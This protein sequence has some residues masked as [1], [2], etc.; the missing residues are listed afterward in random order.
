MAADTTLNVPAE[1]GLLVGAYDLLGLPVFADVTTWPSH[2]ASPSQFFV[3]DDGSFTYTP[4]PGF[5]AQAIGNLLPL[6]HFLRGLRAA[7][8][9][10]ADSATVLGLAWPIALFAALA[11]LVAVWAARR[12]I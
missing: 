8:I 12:R 4:A 10:G 9:R 5:N 7:L 6:T 1:T 11:L 3:N 2:A